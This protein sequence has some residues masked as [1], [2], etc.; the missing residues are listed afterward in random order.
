MKVPNPKTVGLS[1]ETY[2]QDWIGAGKSLVADADPTPAP[3]P[4]EDTDAQIR[5]DHA[6]S[7]EERQSEV[8]VYRISHNPTNRRNILVFE[9]IPSDDFSD[10][11][12]GYA[13]K[14]GCLVRVIGADFMETFEP[15]AYKS[16][17]LPPIG[18]AKAELINVYRY[19]H[20]A[21]PVLVMSLDPNSAWVSRCQEYCDKYDCSLKAVISEK[22]IRF[23]ESK[24]AYQRT[25]AA[26]KRRA[27][28]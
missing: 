26:V 27:R 13:H 23:F 1:T 18:E 25:R 5:K 20:D 14:T 21:P 16:Y 10:R 12:Q 22:Q 3:T 17:D 9:G 24:Q 4:V 11:C 2:Y 28:R 15:V 6:K 19:R 8:R 7:V